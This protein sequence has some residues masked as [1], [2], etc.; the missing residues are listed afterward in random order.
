MSECGVHESKYKMRYAPKLRQTVTP[1][2]G[3]QEL[4]IAPKLDAANIITI[5]STQF[6]INATMRSPSTTPARSNAARACETIRYN[7]A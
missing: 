2:S 6:G 7:S 1:K 3:E 4:Q 5:A